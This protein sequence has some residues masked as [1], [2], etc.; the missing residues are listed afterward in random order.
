MPTRPDALPTLA[1]APTGYAY[2]LAALRTRIHTAQQRAAFPDMNGFSRANLM[3]MRAFAE[4]WPDAEIVQQAVGQLPWDHQLAL[5]DKLR[6][7]DERRWHAANAVKQL[8]AQ[9]RQSRFGV[10]VRS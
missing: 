5:P 3:Y 4:A 9:L 7:M 1:D 8:V 6:T 10:L 2:W